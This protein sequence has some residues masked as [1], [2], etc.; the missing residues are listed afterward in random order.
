MIICKLFL[1]LL[2]Y[3]FPASGTDRSFPFHPRTRAHATSLTSIEY[4]DDSD[5]TRRKK[6]KIKIKSSTNFDLNPP[7]AFRTAKLTSV[8]RLLKHRYES[9]F[10]FKFSN[11][12]FPLTLAEWRS[13]FVIVFRPTPLY[14]AGSLYIMTTRTIIDS[15]GVGGGQNHM[16]E[17]RVPI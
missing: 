5:I 9:V 3:R 11:L 1:F 4:V 15:H 16:L 10:V 7:P 8:G 12:N 14:T 6:K 2:Q 17:A 13:S